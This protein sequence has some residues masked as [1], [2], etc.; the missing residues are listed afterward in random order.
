MDLHG[1][2]T[3]FGLSLTVFGGLLPQFGEIFAA[4]SVR[5]GDALQSITQRTVAKILELA[6]LPKWGEYRLSDFRAVDVESW[7]RG[8]SL[9]NST[10]ARLRNVMHVIFA[11]ACRYEWLMHNPITFFETVQ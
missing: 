8:L 9:A 6:V 1:K 3:G 5:Q 10:K 2:G 4:D 11:Y 7:L